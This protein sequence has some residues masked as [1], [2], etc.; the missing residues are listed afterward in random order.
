MKTPVKLASYSIC[1]SICGQDLSTGEASLLGSKGCAWVVFRDVLIAFS[2]WSLGPGWWCLRS[3]GDLSQSQAMAFSEVLPTR[4]PG[5]SEAWACLLSAQ[6]GE[7]LGRRG[8]RKSELRPRPAFAP[9]TALS[10][11]F[12]FC[13]SVYSTAKWR[14]SRGAPKTFVIL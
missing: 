10:R 8:A 14:S 1:L 12:N 9:G 4:D 2:K 3:P 11:S 13:D 5:W 6:P 7:P